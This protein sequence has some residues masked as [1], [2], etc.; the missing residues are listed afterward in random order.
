VLLRQQT[1]LF[2]WYIPNN[3]I[4]GSDHSNAVYCWYLM[5]IS[6]GGNSGLFGSNVVVLN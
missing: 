1:N 2:F 6:Y 5:E 4:R 3:N